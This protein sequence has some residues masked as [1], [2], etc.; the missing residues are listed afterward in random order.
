MPRTAQLS[1]LL[2]SG[3]LGLLSCTPRS[4]APVDQRVAS[5]AQ[6][7]D[8]TGIWVAEG[9]DTD[10][11]GYPAENG[12]GW[13]M[14]LLGRGAPWN[15]AT[16]EKLRTTM[17]TMLAADAT[18]RAVGWG[19]PAMMDGPPPLQ[20]LIT[21]EETL[22]LNMYRDVRHV[23]TDG[24]RHP[25]AQDVWPTPWGDSVGHWEGDTLV[26][27]TVAVKRPSMI[28]FLPPMLTEQAHYVE[29]LR[30]T[31]ADR[32]ELQM[33]IEDAETLAKPW[34]IKVAFKR[35]TTVDRLIHDTFDNDRSEVEGS[36]LTIAPPKQ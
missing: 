13:N 36:S 8:W 30:K 33:T 28:P 7:P 34:V 31:A 2:G 21:P 19:F 10:V 26:I 20:F 3:L 23:Y 16:A 32:I 4:T 17:P 12:P 11:S 27:D 5:F 22:L 1:L 25:A 6:L 29:R 18:R 14:Q 35:A 9:M 24:R 15:E